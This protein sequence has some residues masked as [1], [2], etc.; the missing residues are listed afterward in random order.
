VPRHG[1]AR[2]CKVGKE[3]VVGLIAAMLRFAQEDDT[4]RNRRFSAITD[5]LCSA[6][7]L[8][9]GLG[10]RAIT[11]AAHADAPLVVVDIGADAAQVA[12]RLRAATPSI[13]VDSTQADGARSC[14]YRRVS[15]SRTPN[16]LRRDSPGRSGA[17][18]GVASKRR[19][20][21]G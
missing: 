13:H 15:R 4:A 9:P 12:A 19:I 21:D 18:M 11:D 3:Q 5:A 10:V 2:S 17:L 7:R 1:I 8:L 16:P 6:L 14:W 20:I